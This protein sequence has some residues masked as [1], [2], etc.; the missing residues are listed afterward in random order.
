MI[1]RIICLVFI[2]IRNVSNKSCRN[3]WNSIYESGW[4]ETFP[5]SVTFFYWAYSVSLRAFRLASHWVTK[6]RMPF[7]KNFKG[8]CWK[9]VAKSLFHLSVLTRSSICRVL[10]SVA[11]C[12]GSW[13]EM[14]TVH[15]VLPYLLTHV[16][17]LGLDGVASTSGHMVWGV[18]LDCMDTETMSSN[19]A[20]GMDA[21]P[22]PFIIII[23]LLLCHQCY[24]S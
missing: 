4:I 22:C 1:L 21:C 2:P 14:W 24:A 13:R 18:G 9:K 20:W 7:W 17:H 19:P 10:A 23:H 5:R 11:Q 3:K 12:Y 8:C 16:L 6:H 15:Q